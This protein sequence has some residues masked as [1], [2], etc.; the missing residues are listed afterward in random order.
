MEIQILEKG[1][2]CPSGFEIHKLGLWP[3][4]KAGCLCENG[5]YYN[6]AC[7]D[8]TAEKCEK[9]L[10]SAPPIEMYEWDNSIWCVKKAALKVDYVKKAE[11][12]PGY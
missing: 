8:V 3:G 4:T 10:P 2:T 1:S 7:E 11:C 12:S 9:D 5:D 6:S